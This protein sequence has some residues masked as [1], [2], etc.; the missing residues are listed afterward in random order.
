MTYYQ[1]LANPVLMERTVNVYPTSYA[2]FDMDCML[3]ECEEGGFDLSR[4]IANMVKRKK[5]A[6]KGEMC[7]RGKCDDLDPNHASI[8][9]DISISYNGKN[10]KNTARKTIRKT[11]SKH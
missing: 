6:T 4:I 8:S 2:Y 10:K 9:Y 1:N 5:T 3:K 11:V 7:C